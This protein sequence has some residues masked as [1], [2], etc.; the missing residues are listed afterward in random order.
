MHK[1]NLDKC[2]TCTE[3]RCDLAFLQETPKTPEELE[4]IRF[5][6]KLKEINNQKKKAYWIKEKKYWRKLA[7]REI[8]M[9][10]CDRKP[11]MNDSDWRHDT[12]WFIAIQRMME[13]DELYYNNIEY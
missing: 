1:I 13:L 11:Y 7:D 5:Q 8:S 6:K 3:K 12:N 9:V 10:K 4:E 2:K